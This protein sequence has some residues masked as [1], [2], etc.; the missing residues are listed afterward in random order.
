MASVSSPDFARRF[1]RDGTTDSICKKC[2]RIIASAPWEADLDSAERDH[3][4]DPLIGERF[5]LSEK[6]SKRMPMKQSFAQ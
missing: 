5:Q 3:K 4:C 1:K 6:P 2:F